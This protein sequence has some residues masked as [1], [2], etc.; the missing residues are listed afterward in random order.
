MNLNWPPRHFGR[1]D[2]S[3]VLG[4]FLAAIDFALVA[5]MLTRRLSLQEMRSAATMA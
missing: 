5:E 4:D 3:H 2:V 1:E